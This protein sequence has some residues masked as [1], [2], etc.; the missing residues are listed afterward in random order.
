MSLTS[1]NNVE[2][3]TMKEEA[4]SL[5]EKAFIKL[6]SLLKKAHDDEEYLVKIL[7]SMSSFYMWKEFANYINDNKSIFQHLEIYKKQLFREDNDIFDIE[8]TIFQLKQC[9]E[10]LSLFEESGDFDVALKNIKYDTKSSNELLGK[11]AFAANRVNTNSVPFEKDTKIEREIYKSLI[12]HFNGRNILSKKDANTIRKIVLSKKYSDVFNEPEEDIAYR[13][14]NVTKEWLSTLVNIDTLIEF[15]INKKFT[16]KP[17]K[18][19]SSWSISKNRAEKFAL[20]GSKGISIILIA[21]V[22]DNSKQFISGTR[23]LYK[24]EPFD[25]YANELEVIGLGDITV[26]SIEII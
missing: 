3:N 15:T 26:S 21:N 18:G 4:L 7:L 22:K 12:N 9:F 14:M 11:Y 19:A 6:K 5:Y 8:S 25:G 1:E 24:I 16:F 17:L 10:R 20:R 2:F 13:G 23:G